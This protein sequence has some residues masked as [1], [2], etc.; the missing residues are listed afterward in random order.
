MAVKSKQNKVSYNPFK[1]W[2]S[3]VGAILYV[4]INYL[5]NW[6]NNFF[7]YV[8]NTIFNLGLKE[9]IYSPNFYEIIIYPIT[10]ITLGIVRPLNIAS[11]DI[12]N[13]PSPSS[14]VFKL[15]FISSLLCLIFGFL[16]GWLVHSLCRYIK[17]RRDKK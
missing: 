8:F 3:Y 11:L 7:D 1:M 9:T 15:W 14:L 4:F 2:G 17:N 10:S 13:L 16:L 12:N 5:S 6:V